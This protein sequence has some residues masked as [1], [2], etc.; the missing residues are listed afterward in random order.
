MSVQAKSAGA[1]PAGRIIDGMVIC[2]VCG[3]SVLHRQA[4]PEAVKTHLMSDAEYETW[5]Y[6]CS[7]ACRNV[8][9]NAK[10]ERSKIRCR[11]CNV[12]VEVGARGPVPGFCSR[13]CRSTQQS[14]VNRALRVVVEGIPEPGHDRSLAGYD[15]RRK[16]LE[17]IRDDLQTLKVEWAAT[18]REANRMSPMKRRGEVA[19]NTPD[20]N[21][22]LPRQATSNREHI[23]RL[24][25]EVEEAW[26][27]RV[28]EN[29]HEAQG[30]LRNAEV[31][32]WGT[33]AIGG[34]E[35]KRER[36]ESFAASILAGLT[37]DTNG[38]N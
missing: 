17:G 27:A 35:T 38:G 11:R 14:A 12:P 19:D 6:F 31:E 37:G 3:G 20:P 4:I 16:I 25:G 9:I 33:A 36:S 8:D 24:M 30:A 1:R 26:H 7:M 18:W 32:R 34:F 2:K 22:L 10:V 28:I 29:E 5:G 15:K 23:R 13:A 21:T